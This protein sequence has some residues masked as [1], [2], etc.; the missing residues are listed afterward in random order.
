MPVFDDQDESPA[1]HVS[2]ASS[3]RRTTHKKS[4]LRSKTGGQRSHSLQETFLADQPLPRS[5]SD[6]TDKPA[7]KVGQPSNLQN[8]EDNEMETE[9]AKVNIENV[10]F[11]NSVIL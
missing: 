3:S 11:C 4:S 1:K 8:I 10:H 7:V 5:R 6:L 2:P 9:E